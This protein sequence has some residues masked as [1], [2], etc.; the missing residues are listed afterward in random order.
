MINLELLCLLASLFLPQSISDDLHVQVS[1][2]NS[3]HCHKI[4]TWD[5]T[6]YG[7]GVID[8]HLPKSRALFDYT[9]SVLLDINAGDYAPCDQNISLTKLRVIKL[10]F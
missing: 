5:S 4:H 10:Q 6:K 8:N 1:T 9:L 2:E 3:T 7:V